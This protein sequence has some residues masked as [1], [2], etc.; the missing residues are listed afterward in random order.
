MNAKNA[1]QRYGFMWRMKRGG[2]WKS[3]TA[4]FTYKRSGFADA[5]HSHGAWLDD[6]TFCDRHPKESL[7]FTLQATR[8]AAEELRTRR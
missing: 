2:A 4:A 1:G 6:Q 3:A 7:T 8:K 5:R